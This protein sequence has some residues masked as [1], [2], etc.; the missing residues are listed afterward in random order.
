MTSWHDDKLTWWQADKL[1]SWHDDKLTRIQDV[2]ILGS[3]VWNYDPL[4]YSLTRVKSRDASASK[5][6]HKIMRKILCSIHPFIQKRNLKWSE[7]FNNPLIF[8]KLAGPVNLVFNWWLLLCSCKIDFAI[9]RVHQTALLV[10]MQS[11]PI[12]IDSNIWFSAGIILCQI[13]IIAIIWYLNIVGNKNPQLFCPIA[14]FFHFPWVRA[15]S[16]CL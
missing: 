8:P 9:L 5:K 3:W 15:V 14:I 10:A 4:S 6:L 1:T 16:Q 12:Y 2:M 11:W 13:N 7:S